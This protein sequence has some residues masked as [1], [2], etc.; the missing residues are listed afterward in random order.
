MQDWNNIDV[1]SITIMCKIGKVFF[2]IYY[3]FIT[4]V[5]SEYFY[6]VW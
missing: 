1:C 4:N 3:L 2:A 6:Y 5:L